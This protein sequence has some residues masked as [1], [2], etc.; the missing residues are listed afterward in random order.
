[1]ARLQRAGLPLAD[2]PES[3]AQGGSPLRAGELRRR[4]REILAENLPRVAA[5]DQRGECAALQP[6]DL[7]DG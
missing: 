5:R 3:V 6:L 4:Q 2:R 7:G 1:M